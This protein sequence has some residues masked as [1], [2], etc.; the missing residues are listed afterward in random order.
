L[1]IVKQK[2]DEKNEKLE[3]D[4][5]NKGTIEKTVEIQEEKNVLVEKETERYGKEKK[6]KTTVKIMKDLHSKKESEKQIQQRRKKLILKKELKKETMKEMKRKRR[7]FC[8][9]CPR[10]FLFKTS[11]LQHLSNVHQYIK[12]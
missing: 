9:L 5:N 2:F 8:S 1:K 3:K 7:N 11:L 10:T 4:E 12:I 6:E